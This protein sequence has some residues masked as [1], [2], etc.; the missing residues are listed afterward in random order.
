MAKL[1]ILVTIYSTH[2]I[3][4]L[5]IYS[6]TITVLTL[7]SYFCMNLHLLQILLNVIKLILFRYTLAS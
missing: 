7:Y 1:F 5:N 3:G 2:G 4:W 6:K